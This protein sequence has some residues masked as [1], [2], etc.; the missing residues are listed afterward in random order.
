MKIGIIGAGHIGGTLA[1]LFVDAGHEI[2]IGNSRGPET[3]RELIASLGSSAQAATP[4]EAARFGEVVVLA[5]PL[6][7][8]T[9]LPADALRG[10]VVIDAMNY[11]PNRDGHYAQVESGELA[12]SELVAAALPGARVV[13]A[14]NTIWF[15]HL[16]A[17]G[18]KDASIEERRAI[19]LSGDDADAK[20][21]VAQLIEE[22]GFGAYDLGSLHESRDQQPDTAVYNRDVTVREARAIAPR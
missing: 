20:R 1:K 17:K 9:T 5:I 7:D 19:F 22:I 10:K 8:H 16:K 3:L 4:V 12:S 6:K 14:F 15:E 18:K 11:Y 2:A 21:I 13:K